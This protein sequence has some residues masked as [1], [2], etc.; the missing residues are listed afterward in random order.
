MLKRFVLAVLFFVV[1]AVAFAEAA[2]FGL[3]IGIATVKDVRNALSSK[4]RLEDNGFNKWSNGPMI[5]ADGVGLEIEGLREAVFIF[6]AQEKLVGVILD[7]PKDRYDSIK[8]YL[9]SKYQ[10]VS[11]QA[12]F[13]G[14]QVATFSEGPVTITA[15]A[16]HMSFEMSVRYIHSELQSAIKKGSQQ[17]RQQKEKSESSKF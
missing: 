7:L 8:S 3:P 5:K 17:E 16:P 6:N 14:N 15:D 1:P 13:V 10:L 2:P 9:K 11:D 12:P 4:T